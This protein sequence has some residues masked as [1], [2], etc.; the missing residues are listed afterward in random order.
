MSYP[1]LHLK[2]QGNQWKSKFQIKP[3]FTIPVETDSTLQSHTT[4]MRE[5]EQGLVGAPAL[6]AALIKLKSSPQKSLS[7]KGLPLQ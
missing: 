7:E 5:T 1:G 2:E 4:D 6:S 3:E